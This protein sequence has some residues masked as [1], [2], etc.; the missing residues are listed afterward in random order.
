METIYLEI[1]D[2]S[3]TTG[4][5]KFRTYNSIGED[6]VDKKELCPLSNYY[7]EA[8]ELCIDRPSTQLIKI[9]DKTIDVINK[10]WI[11]CDKSNIKDIAKSVKKIS[12]IIRDSIKIIDID[13]DI[14]RC[15]FQSFTDNIR[16]EF[17]RQITVIENY[18]KRYEE[19]KNNDKIL[20]RLNKI[21]FGCAALA[22]PISRKLRDKYNCYLSISGTA[23]DYSGRNIKNYCISKDTRKAYEA[24]NNLLNKIYGF[25]FIKCHLKYNTRRYTV[26]NSNSGLIYQK[27]NGNPIKHPIKFGID[28]T[29]NSNTINC[30]FHYSCCER[31]IL[32]YMDFVNKDSKKL[33]LGKKVVNHLTAYEFRIKQKPC[34]MCR[35]AL[36]GCNSIRFKY[37]KN[38]YQIKLNPNKNK[39]NEPFIVG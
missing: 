7:Y 19:N 20:Y 12:D 21:N 3:S 25:K 38:K 24:I 37:L 15:S 22:M 33:L 1:A 26:V 30:A 6:E 8:L 36:I 10:A 13:I 16:D 2:I 11:I 34:P 9:I 28:Y 4:Y 31:K 23:K 17:I 32:A 29:K 27:A 14:G 39:T 5:I 18:Y 35:P